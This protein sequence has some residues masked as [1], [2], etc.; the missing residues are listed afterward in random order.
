[1]VK[2]KDDLWMCDECFNINDGRCTSD[3]PDDECLFDLKPKW[4]KLIGKH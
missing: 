3:T 2:N 4:K 1:M